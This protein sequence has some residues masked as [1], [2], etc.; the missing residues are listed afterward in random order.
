MAIEA[1][2]EEAQSILNEECD[3]SRK[4]EFHRE[5][6]IVRTRH[7]PRATDEAT[8]LNTLVVQAAS[9]SVVRKHFRISYPEE[10]HRFDAHY[11]SQ[12]FTCALTPSK[13]YK[14][15]EDIVLAWGKVLLA[16]VN[17]REEAT[18]RRLVDALKVAHKQNW[19]KFATKPRHR[20]V[21]SLATA[22]PKV[23]SQILND[24]NAF[25][26][27]HD[28]VSLS[29]PGKAY[30]L[31][32]NFSKGLF[33]IGPAL[34]CNFFKELGLLHYVK[35]DVHLAD[36]MNTIAACENVSSEK[37][38]FILS[39]LLAREA[40]MEPYYLDKMLYVGG[41]Y[42]KRRL[43]KFLEEKRDVYRNAVNDLIAQ[44]PRYM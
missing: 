8:I 40:G 25:L 35:I 21:L 15:W 16:E 14:Q 39:W 11:S 9:Y 10:I 24:A 13:S 7:W 4:E 31:A 33:G 2:F 19:K 29:H 22:L 43:K 38:Q 23:N 27:K 3:R 18:L 6:E 34:T 37:E 28:E 5:F 12:F 1:I 42:A 41:K 44:V 26:S 20:I 30:D 32:S 36:F 17:R